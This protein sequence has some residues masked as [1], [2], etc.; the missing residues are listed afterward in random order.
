LTVPVIDIMV[1][2][3]RWLKPRVN[4]VCSSNWS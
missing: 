2:S 3:K 1:V 4:T